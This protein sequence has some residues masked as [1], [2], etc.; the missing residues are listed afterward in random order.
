MRMKKVYKE[1]EI[2]LR[3]SQEDIK[4]YVDRKRSEIE[5][6][7]V[8]DYML[9]STKYLKYQMQERQLEKLMKRFVEPYKVKKIILTN[10]I[11]LEL[12]SSIKIHPV[13]NISR[14]H[15]YKDQVKDQKKEQPVLVVIKGEKEYKVEKILNK[16]KFREKNKYL[17]W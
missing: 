15:R 9:L 5:E 4:K 7:Q 10:T 2:A 11:E 12:P 3:K 16:R 13:V 17:V 14:V 1:A 6:Y 8:G